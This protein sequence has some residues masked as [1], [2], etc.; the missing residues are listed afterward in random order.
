MNI[1]IYTRKSRLTDIGDS[2][3][4]QEET[5]RAYIKLNY[6]E[7]NKAHTLTVYQDEGF[8]GGN[9]DRPA[10][11]SMMH[12]VRSDA[13]HLIICYRLDR[14]SRNI[15]DFSNTYRILEAHHVQFI[16][17][18]EQFDTTTPM[19]RAMLSIALVFSQLERETI[20]E[21]IKDNL[22]ALSEKGQWLGGT[23]PLGYYSQKVDHILPNG[24]TKKYYE[25]VVKDEEAD[26]VRLIFEQYLKLGSITQVER[27]LNQHNLLSRN[28]K[29]YAPTVIQNILRNPTYCSATEEAF[30]YFKALGCH[31]TFEKEQCH[32][33]FGILPFNRCSSGKNVKKDPKEWVI[34]LGTHKP[35][36]SSD[37]WLHVQKQL[38]HNTAYHF[39]KSAKRTRVA[40]LQDTLCCGACGSKMCITNQSLLKDGT[41]SFVYRCH[42]KLIS[43]GHLCHIENAK[44]HY[45]DQSI[46]DALSTLLPS[47]EAFLIALLKK[48]K[49]I[50]KCQS[51]STVT[52]VNETIAFQ[53][54]K[55]NEIIENILE[56]IAMT[57]NNVTKSMLI[58]KLE[59][60]Q[61]KNADLQKQLDTEINNVAPSNALSHIDKIY[62]AI[63]TPSE[64]MKNAS[65]AEKRFLIDQIIDHAVWYPEQVTL[66]LTPE[67]R[68]LHTSCKIT[69][70]KR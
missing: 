18:K 40:L 23:T 57:S 49:E 32:L 28:G 6:P 51:K 21:R 58:N 61:K 63:I 70:E 60:L 62:H 65:L 55:N 38:N 36:I 14:I 68:N 29:H 34:A 39:G 48:E 19:G 69:D 67:K 35:I 66:Y 43:K 26:L 8:S 56:G 5:C 12:A 54:Q 11:K 1:A 16:S 13:I 30:A 50:E 44:G 41:I 33:D 15:A 10:F 31:V 20:A 53:L 22:M 4:M 25:L 9:I 42:N 47:K 7:E 59:L 3:N 52:F 37:Q 17:V 27:Y 64:L 24:K 45:L 46:L 2:I